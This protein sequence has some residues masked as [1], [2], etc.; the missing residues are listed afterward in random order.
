MR[1]NENK[2]GS[3]HIL[4]IQSV[5]LL[6]VMCRR[7][8]FLLFLYSCLSQK[9]RCEMRCTFYTF[10]VIELNCSGVVSDV[11]LILKSPF[12]YKHQPI[13]GYDESIGKRTRSRTFHTLYSIRFT[14]LRNKA[15]L[16]SRCS[17]Y[18]CII[19]VK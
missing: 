2:K 11:V 8:V 6:H 15:S 13:L 19:S 1:T 4:S 5:K 7:M 12:K 9:T 18:L 3:C 17:Y 14:F 10:S 16:M